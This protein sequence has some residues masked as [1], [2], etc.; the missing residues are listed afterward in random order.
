MPLSAPAALVTAAAAAVAAALDNHQAL[1]VYTMLLYI[2]LVVSL[3][4]DQNT[5]LDG[6]DLAVGGHARRRARLQL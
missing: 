4:L 3:Q 1:L 6:R 2:P 5:H